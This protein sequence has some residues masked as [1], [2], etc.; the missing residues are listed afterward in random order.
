[1]LRACGVG[2]GLG[3]GLTC[4]VSCAQLLVRWICREMGADVM[5]WRWICDSCVSV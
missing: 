2:A 3:M 5:R 4:D 1:M